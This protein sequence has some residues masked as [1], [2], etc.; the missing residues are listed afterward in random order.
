MTADSTCEVREMLEALAFAKVLGVLSSL[1][2]V[3]SWLGFPFGWGLLSLPMGSFVCRRV[4]CPLPHSPQI[5]LNW[6]SWARWPGFAHLKQRPL[7]EK[8]SYLSIGEAFMILWHFTTEWHCTGC[9]FKFNSKVLKAIAKASRTK[10]SGDIAR[11][12]ESLQEG[13]DLLNKRQKLADSSEFSWA[14]IKEYL[15]DELADDES[16]SRRI[17]KVEKRAS[18]KAKANREKKRKSTRTNQQSSS[19]QIAGSNWPSFFPSWPYFLPSLG[20]FKRSQ[21][22]CFRCGQLSY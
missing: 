19:G 17:K 1:P 22:L 8:M 7:E 6:Q 16:D 11:A 5:G 3:L 10:A 18:D 20:C 21:D 9:K 15:D 12:K 2:W 14:T 4:W 13:I